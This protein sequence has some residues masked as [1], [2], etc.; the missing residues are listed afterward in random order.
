M[1]RTGRPTRRTE[2]T[3]AP[4]THHRRDSKPDVGVSQQCGGGATE[5]ARFPSPPPRLH[6][7][8]D[9]RTRPDRP[10]HPRREDRRF[11]TGQGRYLDDIV[12]PGALH[13][14]S[15][16]RRMPMPASAHRSAPRPARCRA[17]WRSSPGRDL[18][19]WTKPLRMA[20]PIEG[21][22]P[23]DRRDP[24][25]RQGAL[26][27]RSGR[28]RRRRTPL[29]PPKTPRSRSRWITSRCRRSP[30]MQ[31]ALA[32]D[33]PLVDEALPGNLVSHQSF[34]PATRDAPLR[35]AA[36]RRRGP[37][38]AAPP[39]PRR[40]WRPAAAAPSGTRAAST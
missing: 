8:H 39:D 40:R 24:A 26:P 30:A 14:A 6:P 34:P 21:L 13:A 7:Q 11:L 18:A 1:R 25:G 2:A 37:L 29:S 19:Q 16:A 9:R 38:R 22:H 10:Q 3:R 36:S 4:R 31:A 15:C 5:A 20:P 35:Q 32:P 17:W 28:L 12:D 33:A 27:R 23:V